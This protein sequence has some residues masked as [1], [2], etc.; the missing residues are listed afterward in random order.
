MADDITRSKRR[1]A[2]ATTSRASLLFALGMAAVAAN[3]VPAA[4][5]EP[6]PTKRHDLDRQRKAEAKRARKAAKRLKDA[7]HG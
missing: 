1:I 5:A 7:G 6:V 3:A 4:I 2:G